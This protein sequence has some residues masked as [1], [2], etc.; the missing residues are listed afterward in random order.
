MTLK[1]VE[2]EVEGRKI[3]IHQLSFAGQMRLSEKENRSYLDICKESMNE[4]NYNFLESVNT[5]E[6][7]KVIKAIN[8]V[9]GWGTETDFTKPAKAKA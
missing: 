7:T 5:Q 8:E 9:N 6:G 3:K 4:D 1:E 2:V